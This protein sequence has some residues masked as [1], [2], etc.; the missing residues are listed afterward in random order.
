ME[1]PKVVKC[2]DGY[3]YHT[4]F[5]LG[6]YIIDYSNKWLSRIVSNLCPK[7]VLTS[8]FCTIWHIS[9]CDALLTNL[10]GDGS[11]CHSHKK[12]DFLFDLGILWDEFG[13]QHDVSVGIS[14]SWLQI[15]N[16]V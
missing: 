5:S 10:D 11:Y 7:C 2:P 9:R 15:T 16:T 14:L 12:T 6:P 8:C 1:K 3:F 4:I 13:I